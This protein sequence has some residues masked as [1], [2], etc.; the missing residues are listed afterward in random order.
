[1]KPPIGGPVSGPI[2]AG[3]VSSAIADTSSLRLV[4]RSSTSRPTGVIMA[5]PM[6]C[7]K[8][9]RTKVRSE[10]EMAQNTDP[11]TKTSRA[12]RKIFFAPN[13]SAIQ[14]LIG[15]KIASATM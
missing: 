9:D 5:P 12:R 3:I 2:R 10:S 8:R 4:V 1:M 11:M 6:P 14:P 15:M 13:R 7:R